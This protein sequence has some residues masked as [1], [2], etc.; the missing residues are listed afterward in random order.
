MLRL[1]RIRNFALIKELEI[2][3]GPGLNVLTG[4]TGSGKSILVDAFGIVL[5]ARSS[6]EMIRSGCDAAIIE[7]MFEVGLHDPIIR[8]L[9]EAG[10]DDEENVLLIRREIVNPMSL[11]DGSTNARPLV[12]LKSGD[13]KS[14]N[15]TGRRAIKRST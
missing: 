7:G 11:A 5:G 8:I 9:K 2:E 14:W 13:L 4:E 3:F 6:Q 15:A 1:L 12:I 10:F